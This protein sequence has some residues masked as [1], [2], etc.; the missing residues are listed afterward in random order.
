MI[1]R[2]SNLNELDNVKLLLSDCISS[3]NY[4]SFY[5]EIK[6]INNFNGIMI[7][8]PICKLNILKKDWISLKFCVEDHKNGSIN[9]I[10]QKFLRK[11]MKKTENRYNKI[12]KWDNSS[13]WQSYDNTMNISGKLVKNCLLYDINKNLLKIDKTLEKKVVDFIL[14]IKSVRLIKP[15]DDK[16]NLIGKIIFEIHQLR[17]HDPISHV[18][19]SY[20]FVNENEKYL[21]MLKKGVPRKAVE[22][23]MELD[24]KNPLSLNNSSIQCINSTPKKIMFS[25]SDLK[26]AKLRKVNVTQNKK[27]PSRGINLGISYEDIQ[28]TLKNLRRTNLISFI[29]D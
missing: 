4:H 2:W 16:T 19:N 8:F 5:H 6:Q 11:I 12:I 13:Y 26:N 9:I 23:K 21:D 3:E 1:Y 28:N 17:I 18:S 20:L 27:K 24:G 7:Q 25:A 10:F 15:L 14:N 29:S 22:Q